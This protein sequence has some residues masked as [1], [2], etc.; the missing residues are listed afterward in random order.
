LYSSNSTIAAVP[1]STFILGGQTYALATVLSSAPGTATITAM[2]SGY[3]TIQTTITTQQPSTT[4]PKS[5]RIYVAP[6]RTL[7][8]NTVQ[9]LLLVQLLNGTGKI[10]QP[11]TPITVQLTSSNGDIGSVQPVLEIPMASTYAVATFS[12]TYKAGATTITAG[13]TDITVD[14]ETVTTVG[15]IPSKLA[16][17]CTPSAVP[18][19]NSAYNTIE[20]QLQ[21]SSGKPAL[22][23]DG[24]VT[25]SL[26]SSDPTVGTVPTTLTIP[27]G[28]TYATAI[29][30]S[31]YIAKSTTITAQAS[32]YTTGTAAMKTYL[33]DQAAMGVACTAEP[34]TVVSGKQTNITIYVTDPG[35]NS[36][37]GAT[38]KFT[39]SA[40]GT[41]ATV[42]PLET[43]YYTTQFTVPNFNNITEITITAT[44]TKT[45]YSTSYGTIKVTVV[46]SI[47]TGPMKLCVKDDE[48]QPINA[49]TV[50]SISKPAGMANLTGIT[51]STGYVTFSNA[52]EGNYTFSLNKEGYDPANMSLVFK[53][54]STSRTLFLT[55]SV[56]SNQ[57]GPDLTIAWVTIVVIAIVVAGVLLFVRERRKNAK[58]FHIPK[59]P[60]PAPVKAHK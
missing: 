53:T 54:N 3:T 40:G 37:S 18:A 21:D 60:V 7:A 52:M 31:K 57:P 55:K 6:T 32:G 1:A 39:S 59:K 25:V 36:I 13:A 29:F 42:K 12:T 44:V 23:P 48:G 30:T 2:A 58:K 8:D 28:K 43:G 50:S 14:T 17:Y 16:V 9:S 56:E 46:S 24:D 47:A 15:P 45:D 27:Y 49:V 11:A 34:A 4:V 33:I 22:D 20:V 26:F 51:N 10:T 5:L 19:D 35:T 38:V 41:F